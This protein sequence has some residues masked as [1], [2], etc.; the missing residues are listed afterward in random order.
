MARPA[1]LDLR[2]VTR[3]VIH[4]AVPQGSD[5]V[6]LERLAGRRESALVSA[7]GSRMPSLLTASGR[8]FI[9]YGDDEEAVLSAPAPTAADGSPAFGPAE[10]PV[11]R[12]EFAAIRTRRWAEERERCVAGFK[13]FAVPVMYVGSDHV[14]A[15]VSATV[16]V[17]RRDEQ[18][19]VYA[20]W[21]TAADIGRG[22]RRAGT[23]PRTDSPYRI[24]IA[25]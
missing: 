23:A 11:L 7:V 5:C 25:G 1:L 19:L 12:A 22:F 20:L 17:D 16:P 10:V 6:Y 13:T 8:V 9:A 21:A 14:I 3:A 15:A 24:R 4:L 18:Q 2:A